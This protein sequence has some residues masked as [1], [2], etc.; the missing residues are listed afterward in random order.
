MQPPWLLILMMAVLT[1]GGV[2][3]VQRTRRLGD[4]ASIA[5]LTG[6]SM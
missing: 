4:L 6:R 3:A 1:T 5:Q 2:L